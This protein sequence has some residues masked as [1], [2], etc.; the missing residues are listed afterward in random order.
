[1]PYTPIKRIGHGYFGDVFLEQDEG[2]G[3]LCAAKYVLPANGSRYQE[4]QDMLAVSHDNVV[5]IYSADDDL[6]SGGIVIRMEYHQRGSLSDNYGGRPGATDSVIRHIE[7]ACRGLQHLHTKGILHRDIKPANLLLS[8]NYV[9]K[10]SDF[11]LSKPVN[12]VPADPPIGYI[13]HLPPEAL[14]GPGEIVDEA[15][16]IFAMGVTLYRLLEGDALL[17]GMRSKDIDICHEIVTG[18]F[19]PKGFAPNIHDKLRRV[20]RKATR[21]DP[22]RRYKSAT[23]MRYALEAAR[24]IVSWVPTVSEAGAMTWE[25]G[26][27]VEDAEYRAHL[28]RR[29]D[30][31]WSFWLEKKLNGKT[32]RRQHALGKK[33]MGRTEALRHAS[34]VLGGIASPLKSDL[35]GLRTSGVA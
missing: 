28:E 23:E 11:G 26:G 7:Q 1:M 8:D 15:G 33:G 18:K 9:V 29:K 12:S 16:D 5:Q 14:T 19:P 6:V 25:G 22:G 21:A 24:P 30:G 13:A 34:S 3:R 32:A 20:V 35:P 31:T 10:L 17:A 2:L 4:A 27:T